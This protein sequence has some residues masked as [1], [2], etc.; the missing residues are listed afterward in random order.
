VYLKTFVTIVLALILTL[1][2]STCAFA[3]TLTKAEAEIRLKRLKTEI[4]DLKKELENT[5]KSYSREQ[6]LLKA[7]DLRIQANALELRKLESSRTGHEQALADLHAERS[8]YLKSINKRKDLLASQMMAAYRLGRESRLKLVLNQDSPALLSRTIAYFDYF[9]RSQATQIQELKQVLQ[10]LDQ[11]QIKINMELSALD[12]V[13]INLQAVVDKMLNQRNERQII[14]DD[15]SQQIGGEETRLNELMQNSRDLET[16]LEK[17][18]NV[19]A[20]IPAD[21]GKHT[22]PAEL[23][24]KMAMPV[25]GQV[26][27]AYGHPRPGGLH[28]QGWLV[29]AETGSEVRA[30]AYGRVAFSDW[31][32]GYGLLMIIDHGD[33]FMSLYGNNESLLHEVGDWVERGG[34]ISTVGNSPANGAGLYF[35]IRKNSKALDPAVWLKR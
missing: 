15:L 25:K 12:G 18:S 1:G 35:E 16:L 31:L 17:L 27:H 23:K 26:E 14:I 20:D 24:G 3:Q 6:D 30:I 8:D 2:C 4:T 32:R 13:Q 5:R 21:L 10:T 22:G 33:G 7:A 9:N 19:L 34:T 11:M 28:W 29:A